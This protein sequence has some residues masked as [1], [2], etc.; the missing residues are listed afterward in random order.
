M[1]VVDIVII[2]ILGVSVLVGLYRGFISSV[3]SVGG[4]L[5]SLGLSFWLSPK[6]ASFIQSR[7]DI[8]RL[9]KCRTGLSAV[10]GK[11][12]FSEYLKTGRRRRQNLSPIGLGSGGQRSRQ[13]CRRYLRPRS[14]S[15]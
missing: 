8:L 4:C 3:A 5:L 10:Y 12:L 14:V 7:P 13:R 11:T 15:R 6:L 9:T 1:N 2:G